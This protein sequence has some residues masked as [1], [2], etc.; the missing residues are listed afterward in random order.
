MKNLK[1]LSLLATVI[2]IVAVSFNIADIS[3]KKVPPT[4]AKMIEEQ[5]MINA[6]YDSLNR[7][8]QN[9]RTH[10]V[11]TPN[12]NI[13]LNLHNAQLNR[14]QARI[15]S[16]RIEFNH[17]RE[18]NKKAETDKGET[19]GLVMLIK[20]IFSGIFTIAALYIVLSDKYGNDTKKWAFSIL[21]LI[22][23]V[24]IGTAA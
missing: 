9:I 13:S 17:Y 22:A 11:P 5:K 3:N 4:N 7:I 24:W 10:N 19:L 8:T 6:S 1:L 2:I 12:N 20:L 15:N 18:I 23:G 21:S 16:N 14:L